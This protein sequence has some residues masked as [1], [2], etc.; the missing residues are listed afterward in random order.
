MSYSTLILSLLFL[1]L[2]S[3]PPPFSAY[4]DGC[5]RDQAPCTQ[6]GMYPHAKDKFL[7]QLTITSLK[8]TCAHVCLFTCNHSC[9]KCMNN[10]IYASTSDC[11]PEGY[12]IPYGMTCDGNRKI[13]CCNDNGI[14]VGCNNN[15]CCNTQGTKCG[16][17][18]VC[19]DS[20]NCGYNQT[21]GDNV[22]M[23]CYGSGEGC[24]I[25]EDVEC[26][27]PAYHC[28]NKVCQYC[29]LTGEDCTSATCCYEDDTCIAGKCS[30]NT[31]NEERTIY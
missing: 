1:A 12:C 9:R 20:L 10:I 15:R 17:S 29:S 4:E 14:S 24:S 2:S 18:K 13:K 7:C 31:A 26:C 5:F 19:C 8:I 11:C 27:N 30:K 21:T 3:I 25:T 23:S 6:S 22:C 28:V 16:G